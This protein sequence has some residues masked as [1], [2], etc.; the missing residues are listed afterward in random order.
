VITCR[1]RDCSRA[2]DIIVTFIAL[3]EL[4]RQGFAKCPEVLEE[5]RRR[6]DKER[7]WNAVTDD[8]AIPHVTRGLLAERPSNV[9]KT[10]IPRRATSGLAVILGTS[11]S[12]ISLIDPSLLICQITLPLH[13]KSTLVSGSER[14]REGR[15]RVTEDDAVKLRP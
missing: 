13:E 1:G 5:I 10:L 3:S 15:A 7:D 9:S 11:L 12:R 6:R 8:S 4:L 14:A 2:C